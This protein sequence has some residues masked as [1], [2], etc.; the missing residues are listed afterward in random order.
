[1]GEVVIVST[2]LTSAQ[3]QL[4]PTAASNP[5]KTGRITSRVPPQRDRTTLQVMERETML[6]V[7]R[8]T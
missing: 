6:V 2:S 4:T 7:E 5:K 1:M 3:A 8:G